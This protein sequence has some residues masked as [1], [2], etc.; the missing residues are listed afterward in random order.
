MDQKE[1]YYYSYSFKI[2][3]QGRTGSVDKERVRWGNWHKRARVRET[4]SQV[5]NSKM[6]AASNSGGNRKETKRFTSK[7]WLT[8]FYYCFRHMPKGCIYATSDTTQL[9]YMVT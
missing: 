9:T 1:L 2:K 5:Q 4:K 6:L 8:G 3:I 7:I